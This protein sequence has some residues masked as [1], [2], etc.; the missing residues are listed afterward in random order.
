MA[1]R[2]TAAIDHLNAQSC[3]RVHAKS[4]CNGCW[5]GLCKRYTHLLRPSLDHRP[6]T[7]ARARGA[8]DPVLRSLFISM[9]KPSRGKKVDMRELLQGLQQ[10]PR[11]MQVM[12]S[13]TELKLVGA[14]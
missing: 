14:A 3:A 10:H 12:G 2:V 11:A 1:L 4:C 9:K 13:V 5:Q 6:T 7:Q 8:R